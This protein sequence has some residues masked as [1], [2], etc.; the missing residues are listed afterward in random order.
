MFNFGILGMNARNLQYIKKQNPRKAVRL[1][2]NKLQTKKFLG[3][4]GIPFAETYAVIRSRKQLVN[5]DFST[6]PAKNFVLKPNHGSK[7]RGVCI[8]KKLW[9]GPLPEEKRSFFWRWFSFSKKKENA[10]E[11]Q[12]FGLEWATISEEELKRR[13]IDTL[14]GK[15]SMT[16]TDEAILE[17]KLV[18]WE[19]FKEFCEFWLADLRI[20][21]FKLVPVAAMIR[22]PTLK[23]GGKANL[24]AWG[25]GCWID[26]WSGKITSMLYKNKIYTT[27]FPDEYAH[28]QGKKIPFRND[29]LLYSSK[30]QY[31]VNLGY[32]ALDRVI[33][34]TGPKL[35]EIN[36]RAGLEVQKIADIRLKSVLQKLWD[37][38]I[39]DPE[40]WVDI[41]K[42]LFSREA[43]QELKMS[44]ILY[45]SQSAKLKL[46]AEGQEET[47]SILLEVD[48]DSKKNLI[49]PDL[50]QR[51][52]DFWAKQI[53]IDAPD[54]DVLIKNLKYELWTWENRVVIWQ[55]T[56]S[57]FL[58]KPLK[59]QELSV[60][61][62]NPKK[63]IAMETAQLYL[64]DDKVDK[65]SKRLNLT[66]RLRPVNYF[67]ELDRFISE[68]WNYN[69]IFD[70]K[71]PSLQLQDK[72]ASELYAF[73]DQ[74]SKSYLKSP[75]L[76]LFKEKIDELDHRTKLLKAY[77]NQDFSLI[78]KENIA[79]FWSFD[80]E[81]LKISKEKLFAAWGKNKENWS[82]LS[83]QQVREYIEKYL[84]ERGIFW[85][86]IVESSTT[87]SRMSISI[88]KIAKINISKNI[89]FT[90][91]ELK[92][93]LA[94]EVDI[95]LTRYLNGLKSW[96]NIFKSWTAYYLKDEEW[97]AVWNA[98][99]LVDDEE[100]SLALYRKYYL[101]AEARSLS[102]SKMTELMYL[103]NPN[104]TLEWAFKSILRVKKGQ[105][106]TETPTN[107]CIWMK[108]KVYLDGFMKISKANLSELELQK[109]KKGKIKL[110]DQNFI[111]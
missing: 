52:S 45:L 16:L 63:I 12:L 62:L 79:L 71:F 19:G 40:K 67:G 98:R 32:L 94:H 110:E 49:S 91:N 13:V 69:P 58:I 72:W 59:K 9:K 107:T 15:Y 104:R 57:K 102:F 93:I 84:T 96:R 103:L 30:V 35:L 99:Q 23:S 90:E 42:T 28:F 43:S 80:P 33:T 66:A 10:E 100:E 31:F 25:I 11:V 20:I 55:K 111:V 64:I 101:L 53:F 38:R 7:G 76:Q 60:N 27:K 37:L 75:F 39:Q 29:I 17:E 65:L 97:L 70:Y 46:Y 73:R 47:H 56:A 108:D 95:H 22:I 1:A 21:V 86:E 2:D 61:I 5:F 68:K 3:E 50:Y 51:I 92:L 18:P 34:N 82:P 48:L 41:A 87:F 36:A 89:R 6:L 4:R 26:I 77:T 105:I 44:K 83:S 85:V 78:E 74:L 81:L 14:D 109:L 24:N 8:L 88:W 54:T 106:L